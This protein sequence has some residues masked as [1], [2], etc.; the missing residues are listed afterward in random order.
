MAVADS[1]PP[2]SFLLA[3]L[4]AVCAQHPT[5]DKV[6]LAP[7]LQVGHSLI[8]ALA[9]ADCPSIGLR[10][11]TVLEHARQTALPAMADRRERFLAG[12]AEPFVARAA[13]HDLDLGPLEPLRPHLERPTAEVIRTVRQEHVDGAALRTALGDRTA[14]MP[15][16]QARYEALLTQHDLVDDSALFR[17]AAEQVHASPSVGDAL[18]L[19]FDEVELTE[20]AYRY[21]R[22]LQD[23]E[24]ALMRLG[25]PA[26]P[27]APPPR[28]VAARLADVPTPHHDA[29]AV[30]LGAYAGAPREARPAAPTEQAP[31]RFV[32]A[33]GTDAEVRAALRSALDAGV[34]LDAIEIAYTTPDPYVDLLHSALRRLPAG[35]GSH[36]LPATFGAG[37]PPHLTHTGKALLHFLQWI[38]EDFDLLHLVGMLRSGLVRT[39]GVLEED[40]ERLDPYEAATLL[41]A[42]R[43]RPGRAGYAAM[44]QRAT[45][46]VQ[47]D[48]E[49]RE[50]HGAEVEADQERLAKLHALRTVIEALLDLAPS[51]TTSVREGTRQAITFLG[52]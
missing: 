50:A 5:R 30:G 8:T 39:D 47:R 18:L 2:L 29:G 43:I 11:S 44:L 51:Q 21:V 32:E 24:V 12:G 33:V 7:S 19:L 42:R 17:R 52:R 37:R 28:T 15:E 36:G 13:L 1:A 4:R 41:A 35:D 25:H 6:L 9:R 23:A 10:P 20:A 16:A 27:L 31:F 22:A 40:G 3:Q 34:P 49:E 46:A 14:W 45:R 26:E 48:I 38:E